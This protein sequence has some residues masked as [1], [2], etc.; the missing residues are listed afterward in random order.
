[1]ETE[2][3]ENNDTIH[4]EDC[5]TAPLMNMDLTDVELFYSSTEWSL[6]VDN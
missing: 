1:M 5:S 2:S 6:K 3:F 4:E